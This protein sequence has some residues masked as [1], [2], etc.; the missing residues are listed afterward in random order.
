M[1]MGTLW[2]GWR[3]LVGKG[4]GGRQAVLIGFGVSIASALLFAIASIPGAVSDRQIRDD[5]RSWLLSGALTATDERGLIAIG[6]DRIGNDQWTHVLITQ[7]GSADPSILGLSLESGEVLVSPAL[8]EAIAIAPSLSHRLSAQPTGNLPPQFLVAPDELISVE[9]VDAPDILATGVTRGLP[10]GDPPRTAVEIS[11]DVLLVATIA[12][13]VLALPVVIFVSSATQLGLERRRSRVRVLSLSGAS[14]RQIRLFVMIEAVTA[15]LSGVII[16]YGIFLAARP[17]LARLQVGGRTAFAA[18]L[19]PHALLIVAVFCFVLITAVVTSL[20]ITRRTEAGPI[21]TDPSS[22]TG[23]AGFLTLGFGFIGLAVGAGS[24]STTDAPHPLALLGMVLVAVGLALVGRTA[25]AIAGRRVAT[26]TGNGITMLAARRMDRSSAEINRPLAAVVTAVFVVSAFFTI[27]GT[28]LKSSNPRFEGIP[29][30]GVLIEAAPVKLPE[31]ARK[32]EGQ[33]GVR[34]VVIREVDVSSVT[35][36]QIVVTFDAA[37]ANLEEVRTLVVAG[38]PTAQVRSV[39]EIEYDLSVSARE[40]RTLAAIGLVIVLAIATFSL[41][42]GTASHLLQRRD[43]FAFLRAGGVLP[44]Q[45][46]RLIALETTAPLA[47]SA[48]AGALLGVISG[49]AVAFSA[50]TDPEVP[51]STISIVYLSAVLLG[52]LVWAAF[53][54]LLERLTAPTELRFE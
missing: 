7:G 32:I 15:A 1:S 46:R 22:W 18:S 20:R 43:A 52:V 31:I 34:S 30:D 37:E 41:S 33:P 11:S 23:W 45:V 42:V 2:V 53:T 25:V 10:S 48:A 54:P 19:R 21:A 16:G 12:L 28:L 5:Q 51:W 6:H 26:R 49:A 24:P 40:V 39:P 35:V 38:T 14:G 17:L 50:G 29:S 9:A 13:V 36:D 27:T 47:V 8:S 4:G 44:G 3:L